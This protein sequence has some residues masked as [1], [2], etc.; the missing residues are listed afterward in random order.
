MSL[1]NFQLKA[2]DLDLVALDLDGTVMCPYGKA[3]ISPRIR[4]AVA[5]LLSKGLAVT[6][7]TGRTEDYA[8]P[9]AESFH[10]K[11]PI[12]TY[13][14]GRVY[15]VSE[16]KVVYQAAIDPSIALQLLEF[17]D[18]QQVVVAAYLSSSRGLH[19]VQ[20]RC[21]GRPEHD[22]Y[23]FGTP[24]TFVHSMSEELSR[25]RTLSKVIVASEDQF[26]ELL[27]SRFG[28][29]TKVLRTHPELIEILPC[30]VDKGSGLQE[31]LSRL[32]IDAKRVLA[33]GDQANDIATFQMVGHSV[34][35]GDAP[36]QVRAA[37]DW[38]TGT[39][40]DDGCAEV[41]ERLL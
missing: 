37:A 7:A 3:P 31:L 39:F 4:K 33:V 19:L 26:E 17:L 20:N 16:K 15:C 38:V 29:S 25:G 6:F 11:T 28:K 21:S 9:I 12:V 22:D 32:K 18:T 24:R 5:G 10:I 35:M 27:H 13:N 2:D 8:A 23:L 34:A 41:L 36:E 14:G 30:G 1:S 40:L